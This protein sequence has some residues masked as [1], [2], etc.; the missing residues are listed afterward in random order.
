MNNRPSEL[1]S[2]FLED[3]IRA[4]ANSDEIAALTAEACRG[5]DAALA[6]ILGR[7]GVAALV[8]HSL[9]VTA[10]A[11]DYLAAV[12]DS[13]S[14]SVDI[15]LLQSVLAVQDRAEAAACGLLFLNTFHG[16]LMNLIGASL[17]GQ[18]LRSVWAISLSG[19][20]AQDSPT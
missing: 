16:L 10:R 18:L 8:T 19:T 3:R 7:R 9:Q 14:S 12:T 20:S 5:I 4:G 17:T 6:P 1:L 11:H 15:G 2:A 13:Q